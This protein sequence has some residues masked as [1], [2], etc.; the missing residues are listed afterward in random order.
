MLQ[1]NVGSI[2]G[3]TLFSTEVLDILYAFELL[4]TH[5][6]TELTILRSHFKNLALIHV[7][8]DLT[9]QIMHKFLINRF[10]AF[11]CVGVIG[12]ISLLV[13]WKFEDKN[14]PFNI[15]IINV[16]YEQ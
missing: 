14:I 6:I 3:L 12:L 9:C 7:K 2:L 5:L 8:G 16:D 15:D 10:E 11:A 1:R 13:V 4:T